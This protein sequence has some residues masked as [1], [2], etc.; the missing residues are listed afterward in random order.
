MKRRNKLIDQSISK[1][2]DEGFKEFLLSCNAKNLSESTIKYYSLAAK[3]FIKSTQITN[4]EEADINIINEYIVEL[5]DHLKIPTVNTNIRALRT[6]FYFFMELEYLPRFKIKLLKQQE[7]IKET[8]TDQELKILLKKPNV[9]TC[10]FA[11]YRDW[12]IINFFVGTGCRIRTL[13]NL[14]VGDIDLEKAYITFSVTKNKKPQ[15]IPISKTLLKVLNEYM[16]F[17]QYNNEEEYL[18]CNVYGNIIAQRSLQQSIQLYN[19]ARGVSKSSCHLFR[20]SFA[21]NWILSGG[22]V[23]RLQKILG[24]SSLDVVKMYVNMFGTDLQR[25]FD[26]FNP[27]EKFYNNDTAIKMK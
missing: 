23:F 4:I 21:K 25:D 13:R 1:T 14:K 2:W 15:I 26:V 18:F 16:K 10:T 24:H 7:T 20:H 12:V 5:R 3:Q 19:N 9:K 6:I 17:R 22:D 11:E 8:Y 27:L